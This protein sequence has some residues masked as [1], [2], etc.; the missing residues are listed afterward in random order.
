M[1]LKKYETEKSKDIA[2]DNILKEL[3]KD[4]HNISRWISVSEILLSNL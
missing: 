3:E 4:P 2:T 1:S